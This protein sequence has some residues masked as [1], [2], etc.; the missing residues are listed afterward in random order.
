[1]RKWL[2]RIRGALGMGFTW[3]PAW[4][5]VGFVP[6][7]LFGVSTDLPLPLLF[8][9]LGFIGGVTLSRVLAPTQGRR[10]FDQVSLSHGSGGGAPRGGLPSALLVT[11]AR[12]CRGG[13]AAV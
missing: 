9:A 11:G 8:G 12:A 4:F 6:R 10:K 13:M 7:W 3:A 5:A 2:R 1:M